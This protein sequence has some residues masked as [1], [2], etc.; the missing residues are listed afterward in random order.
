MAQLAWEKDE[1]RAKLTTQKRGE[2]TKFLIGGLLILAAIGYL[3]FSG[4]AVGQRFFI[5]VEEILNDADAKYV[6]QPVRITGAVIGDTI[7]ETTTED[8]KSVITFTIAH[9]P[10]RTDNL[11]ETLNIASNNPNV[12]KLQVYVENQPRPELLRHEAQAILTGT[13]DED[14]TFHATELQFKCPSRFEESGPV[15]GEQDHPGMG[16]VSG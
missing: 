12:T 4:T 13:L 7:E 15:M 2:R 9:I 10:T 11:A 3:I 8:G 16:S 1:L 6:G 5:T 14:G